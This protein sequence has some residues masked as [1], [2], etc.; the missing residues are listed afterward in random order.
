VLNGLQALV[1]VE[2]PPLE[3]QVVGGCCCWQVRVVEFSTKTP[4][5]EQL[6]TMAG[7]G[8]YLS[9][10]T[11]NLANTLFLPPNAAVFEVIQKNWAWCDIDQSFVSLTRQMGGE[12]VA[13]RCP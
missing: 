4:F 11:S 13:A 5:R 6:T 8:V 3:P 2:A 12:A 7:T 9:V 1:V 10:H